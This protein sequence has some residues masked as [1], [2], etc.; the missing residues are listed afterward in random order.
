MLLYLWFLLLRYV[1]P[2]YDSICGNRTLLSMTPN[3]TNKGIYQVVQKSEASVYFCLYFV[4]ALAESD[5]F[6]HT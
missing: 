5:N 1:R 3:S 6:W 2:T 4:N